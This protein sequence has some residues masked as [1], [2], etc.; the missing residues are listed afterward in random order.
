MHR[1]D[2]HLV[3]G[4]FGKSAPYLINLKANKQN[5]TLIVILPTREYCIDQLH[6]KS[7]RLEGKSYRGT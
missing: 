2:F 3:L 1:L 7:E 4:L 5:Y 6:R